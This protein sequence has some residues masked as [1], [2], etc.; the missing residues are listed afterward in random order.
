MK[1][2]KDQC[3]KIR[4]NT[5]QYFL[6]QLKPGKIG[7]NR[8]SSRRKLRDLRRQG[9]GARIEAPAADLR[10]SLASILGSELYLGLH[11]IPDPMFP[12]R[13]ALLHL[14]RRELHDERGA[15]SHNIASTPI[16]PGVGELH[17]HDVLRFPDA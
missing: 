10:N 16:R 13:F 9:A 1:K 5:G 2:F 12:H 4:T 15:S 8:S 7:P 3:P 11:L 6:H 17:V 14:L